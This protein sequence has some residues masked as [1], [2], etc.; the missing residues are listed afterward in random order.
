MCLAVPG[1]LVA[2][3][4]E[5]ELTRAGRVDF[6]GVVREVNL[7]LVPHA[8]LGDYVLVHV[9][10]ALQRV[11]EADARLTL[12]YLRQIEELSASDDETPG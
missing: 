9:G 10:M 3:T 7:S 4:A 11:D 5:G 8:Q 12:D 1:R 6:G 2:L